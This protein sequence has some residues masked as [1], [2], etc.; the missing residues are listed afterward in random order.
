[1][2]LLD[3]IRSVAQGCFAVRIALE[4]YLE[5]E[6]GRHGDILTYRIGP[7]RSGRSHGPPVAALAGMPAYVLV[8][9]ATLLAGYTGKNG[10]NP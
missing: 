3:Q 2:K 8:R 5:A 1:M 6:A 4:G 7:G 9:V 10:I